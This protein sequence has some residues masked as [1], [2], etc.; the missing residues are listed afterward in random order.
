MPK[1]LQTECKHVLG[2]LND[3]I[4][5]LKK[6]LFEE[7]VLSF[8]VSLTVKYSFFFINDFPYFV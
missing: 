6:T 2:I 4:R 3:F 8:F 7:S 1:T 5:F